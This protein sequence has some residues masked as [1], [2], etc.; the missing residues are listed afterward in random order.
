MWVLP[1]TQ[2][3]EISKLS[4]PTIKKFEVNIYFFLYKDK[5]DFFFFYQCCVKSLISSV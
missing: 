3:Q 4:V 5:C 2:T 1:A